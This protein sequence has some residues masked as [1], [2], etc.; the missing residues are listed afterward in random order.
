MYSLESLAPH[1]DPGQCAHAK[2][3]GAGDTAHG[4]PHRA[5]LQAKLEGNALLQPERRG[6]CRVERHQARGQPV[7][8]CP[9]DRLEHRHSVLEPDVVPESGW[10][11]L[12]GEELDFQRLVEKA[13][14]DLGEQ[15]ESEDAGQAH[16]EKAAD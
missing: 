12:G 5:L 7:A 16:A 9:E 6:A 13:D 14:D 10:V 2:A 15:I 4:P 1:V 3:A 11:M 8:V